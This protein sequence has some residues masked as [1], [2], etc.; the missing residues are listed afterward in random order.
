MGSGVLGLR[1]GV[2]GSGLGVWGLGFMCLVSGRR[3][4]GPRF[5]VRGSGV[6][7]SEVRGSGV[8]G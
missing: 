3:V 8:E 5:T 6:R 2:E 1:V 7:G 4:H